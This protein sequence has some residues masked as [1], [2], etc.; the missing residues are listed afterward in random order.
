MSIIPDSVSIRPAGSRDI[1]WLFEL[2]NNA[3]FSKWFKSPGNVHHSE[4]KVWFER[5]LTRNEE[6]MDVMEVNGFPAGYV[7]LQEVSDFDA[8]LVS[9]EVS[10]G[11]DPV[12][13][14]KG[15]A[16]LLIKHAISQ[17]FAEKEI[18]EFFAQVHESNKVSSALFLKFD[19]ER[20]RLTP[21]SNGFETYVLRRNSI[22]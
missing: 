2:R 3:E 4:H 6:F 19:F 14:G 18:F 12:Y 20:D 16:S 15:L 21:V 17:K 10:V 8:D 11:V 13:Q 9:V 5:I 22:G 1:D 7:R